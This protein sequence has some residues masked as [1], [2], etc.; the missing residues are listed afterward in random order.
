MPLE[1]AILG[2]FCLGFWSELPKMGY[3]TKIQTEA[4]VRD[5]EFPGVC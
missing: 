2:Y 5:M 4:G 1:T 3:F